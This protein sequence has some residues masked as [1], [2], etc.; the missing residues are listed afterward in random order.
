MA[1][2]QMGFSTAPEAGR[3]IIKAQQAV[4]GDALPWRDRRL[5]AELMLS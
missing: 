2:A 3:A 5:F 1:L 4:G